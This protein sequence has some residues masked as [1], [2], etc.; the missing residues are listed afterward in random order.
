MHSVAAKSG[1]FLDIMALSTL[2]EQAQGCP[3]PRAVLAFL[4]LCVPDED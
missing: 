2:R 1:R 4:L 3:R